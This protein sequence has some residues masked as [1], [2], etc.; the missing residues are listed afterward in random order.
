MH[1]AKISE[2]LKGK[3]E[4]QELTDSGPGEEQEYWLNNDFRSV[5]LALLS[6]IGNNLFRQ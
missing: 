4:L 1:M 6:E 5:R 2:Y 3:G